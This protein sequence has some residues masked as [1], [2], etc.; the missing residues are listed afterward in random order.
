[1]FEQ[2]VAAALGRT[3]S[4]RTVVQQELERLRER[5][6]ITEDPGELTG[7]LLGKLEGQAEQAR[8]TVGPL[9]LGLGSSLRDALDLPSRAEV[10]AL[11]R[12]L[13]RAEAARADG[14]EAP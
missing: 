2:F 5:G 7:E 8:Q 1:M 11:T 6:Y 10:L 14:D 13:E 3:G 9:I 12:A 4:I